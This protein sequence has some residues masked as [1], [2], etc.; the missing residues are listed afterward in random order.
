MTT[1]PG[2]RRGQLIAWKDERGFGFIQPV[3]GG[4][5][6]FLHITEVKDATR[7]PIVGDTIYYYITEQDGKV[8]ALNAFILGARLKLV[9]S[10]SRS[11]AGLAEPLYPFPVAK[12]LLLSVFPL[13]GA[14]HFVLQTGN[15]LP[16][17]LYPIASLLSYF[18]YADDKSRAK[19]GI[20]RTPEKSLI[21]CDLAGGWIGGFIAQRRLR[22]KV[23]KSSYQTTFWLVVGMHYIFWLGWFIASKDL[24]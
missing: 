19:Q 22:H 14:V 23:S 20:W 15:L 12:V 9:S 21:F 16:L 6:V 4:S 11:K 24:G 1:K 18:Q 10:S 17:I 13:I 8:R 3:D 5:E 7:R 2:L